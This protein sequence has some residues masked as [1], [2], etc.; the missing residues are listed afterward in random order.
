MI[1]QFI[2]I[3]HIIHS[4]LLVLFPFCTNDLFSDI[5]YIFYFFA[6]MFSYTFINGECPISYVSKKILDQQYIAGE[7]ITHYPEML[8]LV[9]TETYIHY[10]FTTMT[11][12]YMFSLFYVIHRTNLP[13][14]FFILPFIILFVYFLFIRNIYFERTSSHFKTIQE[15]TKYSLLFT[16]GFIL[17]YYIESKNLVY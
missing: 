17:N 11:I 5:L 6:I 4:P 7:N 3:F 12:L 1:I 13:L 10:Y 14:Y 8:S 2:G 15:I 9:S 16:M